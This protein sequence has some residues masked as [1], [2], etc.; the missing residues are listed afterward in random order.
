MSD[1]QNV[2]ATEATE[3][4]AQETDWKTEA[5]KWEARAKDNLARASE[6]EAAAKRLAELEDSQKSE[7]EKA[8]A[9]AEQ[10]ERAL[11]ASEL[12]ALR[13]EVA[14][15]KQIPVDLL[16]G[17]TKDELEASADALIAFRGEQ[18]KPVAPYVAREGNNP[19]PAADERREF[20]NRLVAGS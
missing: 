4:P 2:E 18:A 11:Q 7:I 15:A 12:R 3:A 9:R 14:A 13:S 20:L 19:K 16:T 6:N 17:T 8:I 10:A 1:E 5:R